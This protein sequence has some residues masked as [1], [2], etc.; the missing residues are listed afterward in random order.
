MP[1]P[2]NSLT[3]HPPSAEEQL[4]LELTNRARL[5]PDEELDRLVLDADSQTGITSNITSALRFFDVDMAEL[6]RQ[7]ASL[8]AV[9]PLAWNGALAQ[10]ADTHGQLMI[11][12]DSQSHNL[13]GES[14]LLQ[15]ARDAGYDN[16]QV[17]AEN[18]F[19]FAEDP[20]HGHAGFHIDWG[21]TETG[22]QEPPGH[23]I[24]IMNDAF[25]EIGL[26]AI[27]ESDPGTSVGPMVVTQHFGNRFDH[28][29]Q[30]MGVVFD[31]LDNDG[32]YDIGE[33]LGDITVTA[34]GVVGEFETRSWGVGGYQ[35]EVPA[36]NYTVTFS[37][38]ALDGTITLDT[39]LG[40]KNVKLDALAAAAS[41]GNITGSSG[42]DMLT[43]TAGDD[44]LIGMAGDDTL[45]G[46][47]GNDTLDGGAGIDTAVYSGNQAS[48][49]LTLSPTST[50]ITDRRADGNGTD[51]LIDLE[52]LDFD[53]EIPALGGNPLNLE[54]F[55]G[56]TE[57]SENQFSDLIELY[58]AYFNRAPD[59]VGLNF[60]GTAFAD[61]TSLQE[62]ATLLVDQEETE[63][64]YPPGT[65]NEIFAETVYNN[66]L[67]R[68]PDQL[69]FDFWVGQLDDENVSR[70]QFI[71][72][73]LR[74]VQPG[75]P[76]RSYL[77][78]KVDL[79]A[80][81]AVHKGMSD[82]GN[83]ATVM[84]LFDESGVGAAAAAA[85]AID[86]YH[87]DALDPNNGEFLLQVVGVLDD[88]FAVA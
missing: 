54:K 57:L 86:G 44:K 40:N 7:F 38:S 17:I 62:M 72:E 55:G 28:T 83:A 1:Q 74:G 10:S 12:F 63:A 4:F 79:G 58:I 16:L 47:A 59:A 27:G 8:E 71:L 5:Y 42:A 87:S 67:G 31:D 29:P 19:A 24:A 22:I 34:T 65:S 26:S 14:D 9:S 64:A 48:Y 84:E 41:A 81:F 51:T 66:V 85:A 73:V 70:D 35:M 46:S 32:F 68:T 20:V 3:T 23:R 77:D 33:G 80:Y 56:P 82:T 39:T 43:G 25:T 61:G 15:R 13:P 69:G 37:G 21:Y 30:L 88:P 78:N 75:T 60:W 11:N 6:A 76:D 53:T 52:F 50:T 2:S 45:E 36:G 49:T 18:I